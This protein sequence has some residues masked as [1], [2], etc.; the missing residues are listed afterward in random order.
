MR[1]HHQIP[2]MLCATARSIT[3]VQ[4]IETSRR[5]GTFP[6][7]REGSAPQERKKTSLS[8]TSGGKLPTSKASETTEISPKL[9]A[10]KCWSSPSSD[11]GGQIQ[12]FLALCPNSFEAPAQS[13][14]R[15]GKLEKKR[16]R[17]RLQIG[18]PECTSRFSPSYRQ[19]AQ[20]RSCDI[21]LKKIRTCLLVHFANMFAWHLLGLA[22]S[23]LL[24]SAPLF[25][26]RP[27]EL[28]WHLSF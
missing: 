7:D 12:L 3:C 22:C 4:K 10:I 19:Y 14:K 18:Q 9:S 5:S 11:A 24:S 23:I 28:W 13:G 8:S 17:C 15:M 1:N 21:N 27:L 6:Y 26:S 20:T 25:V 16:R 2:T